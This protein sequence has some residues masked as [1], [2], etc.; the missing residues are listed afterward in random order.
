MLNARESS[1]CCV[2]GKCGFRRQE[3]E[4]RGEG[5]SRAEWQKYTKVRAWRGLAWRGTIMLAFAGY[6]SSIPYLR[7]R[8]RICDFEDGDRR[9]AFGRC[10][11]IGNSP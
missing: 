3:F 1:I 5:T 7:P 10:F 2:V 8:T 6:L 9:N 11:F 4:E